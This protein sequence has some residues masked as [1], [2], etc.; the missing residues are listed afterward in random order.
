MRTAAQIRDAARPGRTFPR[1]AIDAGLRPV[2]APVPTFAGTLPSSCAGFSVCRVGETTTIRAAAP[3]AAGLAEPVYAWWD[4]VYAELACGARRV[5]HSTIAHAFLSDD[6]RRALSDPL[7]VPGTAGAVDQPPLVAWTSGQ[8]IVQWSGPADDPDVLGALVDAADAAV[9]A[10]GVARLDR[11]VDL[12]LEQGLPCP[13]HGSEDEAPADGALAAVFVT[14]AAL[15]GGLVL[16]A[17]AGLAGAVLVAALVVAVGVVVTVHDHDHDAAQGARAAGAPGFIADLYAGYHGLLVEDASAFQT[18][19]WALGVA[20]APAVVL[21]GVIPGTTLSGRILSGTGPGGCGAAAVAVAIPDEMM[22]AVA[23]RAE[24]RR[25]T[26]IAGGCLL[27]VVAAD[28][29]PGDLELVDEVTR[30]TA[31]LLP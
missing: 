31:E 21:R 1:W 15:A 17:G 16:A 6:L 9:V 26:S 19:L 30:R 18:R 8:V 11:L 25:G 28:V 13:T 12:D 3:A 22:M 24:R 29:P 27:V 7:L 4:P 2:A 14:V 5:E 20:C 10:V 23:R